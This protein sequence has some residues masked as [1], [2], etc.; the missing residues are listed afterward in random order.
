M[1]SV[2]VSSFSLSLLQM[3]SFEHDQSSRN[4][5]KKLKQLNNNS[6]KQTNSN[7]SMYSDLL[8][9][10]AARLGCQF[11]AV[12]AASPYP[13]PLTCSCSAHTVLLVNYEKSARIWVV[14]CVYTYMY[15]TYTYTYIHL[16][17]CSFSFM[18]CFCTHVFLYVYI[19][20]RM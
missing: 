12:D 9:R 15:I 17:I 19:N 6:P 11:V 4:E 3:P 13:S 20:I 10:M 5:V 8:P 14:A 2:M 18:Y 7:I 1:P 16:C